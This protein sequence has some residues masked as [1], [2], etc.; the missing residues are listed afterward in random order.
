MLISN[1]SFSLRWEPDVYGVDVFLEKF[2]LREE[3]NFFAPRG[4][5]AVEFEN[6]INITRL[7][8]LQNAYICL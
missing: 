3:R 2:C 1:I 6:A 7:T 8:A 4:E 5:E